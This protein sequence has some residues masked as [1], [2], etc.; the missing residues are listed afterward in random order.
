[1]SWRLWQGRD[2]ESCLAVLGLSLR[3]GGVRAT[4]HSRC[5]VDLC[6]LP[7]NNILGSSSRTYRRPWSLS[8]HP[9]RP[10]FADALNHSTGAIS[11]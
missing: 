9:A 5:V 1:M 6:G 11:R 10:S 7:V 2:H 4:H 8:L 3:I